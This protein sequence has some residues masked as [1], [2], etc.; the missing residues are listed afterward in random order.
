MFERWHK[1]DIVHAIHEKDI[2]KVI[3]ELGLL[4]RITSCELLCSECGEPININNIECLYL[5]NDEIKVCCDNIKCFK[6][7]LERRTTDR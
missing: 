6:A 2:E 7:I 4:E 1:R 5:Q 3:T